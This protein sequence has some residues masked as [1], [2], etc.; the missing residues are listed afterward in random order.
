MGD[1]REI[2][3][4]PDRAA[5]AG[6]GEP[7]SPNEKVGEVSISKGSLFRHWV[8]GVENQTKGKII[9]KIWGSVHGEEGNP[10]REAEQ[11]SMKVEE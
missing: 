8:K 1:A 7:E 6:C 5:R 3:F 2:S 11:A 10:S 9:I 4:E